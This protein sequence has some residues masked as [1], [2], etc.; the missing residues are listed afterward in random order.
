MLTWLLQQTGQLFCWII[1]VAPWE[2]ALRI[3]LGNRVTLLVAGWSV[4]VPF[5]DRI[6]RQSIRRR[7]TPINQMTLTT[8]D[9]H[10]V[11]VSGFI[12]YEIVDLVLLYNTLHHADATIAADIS[13]RIANFIVTRDLA[14]IQVTQMEQAVLAETNLAPYGIGK[15]EFFIS[16]FAAVKTY[17][18]ITGDLVNWAM[19]QTALQT[20]LDDRL[21]GAA[22]A[23]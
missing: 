14:Q 15:V 21:T 4:R 13:A 9:R 2:Q 20:N 19:G 5:I 12:G 16:N 23:Q 10:A 7:M 8:R 1:I 11:T 22:P 6:Y 17:R 18:F 3:R